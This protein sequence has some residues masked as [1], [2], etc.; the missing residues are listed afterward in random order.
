MIHELELPKKETIYLH[1]FIKI[2]LIREPA[3]ID[4][5]LSTIVSRLTCQ[6]I[7]F[8]HFKL[9]SKS[10]SEILCLKMK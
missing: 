10:K 3:G 4:G 6:R 8:L 9:H 7:A 2:I 1:L 5:H